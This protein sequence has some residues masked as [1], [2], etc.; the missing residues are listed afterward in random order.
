MS[1]IKNKIYNLQT[2]DDMIEFMKTLWPI[3]RSI[4]GKGLRQTLKIIQKYLPDLTIHNVESGTKVL[5][6]TIPE[7]WEITEGYLENPSGKRIADL[8]TNNLH[9]LGYSTSVN[10]TLSLEELKPHLYTLPEQPDV[11]PYV[12][13]YYQKNWGF[14]LS[15][16]E[17]EQLEE[18]NYKAF[19]N[20]KH[21]KGNLN[22]AELFIQGQ[23]TKE[24]LISTYCCHPSMANN[25][26]SGPCVA[27]ALAQW[28]SSQVDLNYSYRFI[29]AP[30]TIGAAAVLENK[31]EELKQNVFAA[32]NLTCVG[33]ERT[34]SFLPSR[35][36]NT[37]TD[38]VAKHALKYHTKSFQHYSWKDRG[39]DERMY[40]S[41][42]I[43]LPM[44]SVM[45][46]KYGTY[47]EYH[48]SQ[49]TLGNV[50]TAEGLQGSI[51][52]HKIMITI[53]ENDCKPIALV[54]GEPQLGKRGLYPMIS[55]KG[56][57]DAARN[58]LDLISYA[59]GNHSLLDIAELCE[60]DF[61]N[62][63]KELDL[64]VSHQILN[65]NSLWN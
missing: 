55:K 27:V 39:S 2:K 1:V 64:L 6:W 42:G 40:C 8:E 12:T 41:P 24:V 28:L 25:E 10:K 65:K 9:I 57:S 4:T 48:T 51:D 36:G 15:H 35:L 62:L 17:V 56:S 21:F 61:L 22:Y 34:W 54:L 37:Y 45:R 3:N 44:V 49:D 47:P 31:R 20:S 60:V 32:F 50:V 14:C 11:I 13:S 33:D 5:D 29:F 46:S 43:D 7:E 63:K 53:I 16:K 19:I 59:D 23:S 18:G 38:N 26:L 58:R 52:M 30:E